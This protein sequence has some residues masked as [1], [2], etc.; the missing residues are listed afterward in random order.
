MRLDWDTYF[1]NIANEV[2]NRSKDTVTKV[3]AVI[4]NQDNELVSTGYNGFPKGME[5][6]ELDWVSVNKHMYV[7]HAEA[8]A[9]LYA[10]RDLKGCK[11]YTT[12][13]PCNNCAKLIAASGIKEVYY[14][15]LRFDNGTVSLFRKCG[16]KLEE[17]K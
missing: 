7:I 14:N 12:L 4:V 6:D 9:I 15:T 16:I 2:K 17:V 11:I 10:K 5:E 13:S 8:N 3:G 1:M